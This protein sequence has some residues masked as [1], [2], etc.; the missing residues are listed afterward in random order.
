MIKDKVQTQKGVVT[1]L[2]AIRD[3]I[4]VDIQDMTLEEEVEYLKSM[5]SSW[6]DAPKQ[7]NK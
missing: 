7:P 2:K 5:S 1:Q 6:E 3:K 4:N